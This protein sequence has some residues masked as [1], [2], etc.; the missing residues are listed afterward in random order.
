MKNL[1][2]IFLLL[3]FYQ[4]GAQCEL[5]SEVQSEPSTSLSDGKIRLTLTSSLNGPASVKYTLIVP[6][7][8]ESLQTST[9]AAAT[10]GQVCAST[11]DQKHVTKKRTATSN[12][13]FILISFGQS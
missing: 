6:L 8:P 3:T 5:K 13:N 10:V 7:P 9:I 11:R 12:L 2:L 4:V 1:T